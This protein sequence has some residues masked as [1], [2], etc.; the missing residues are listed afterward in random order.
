MVLK[1]AASI[2]RC[3]AAVILVLTVVWPITIPGW[4]SEMESNNYAWSN[5]FR[6]IPFLTFIFGTVV[7]LL[8]QYADQKDK[9]LVKLAG[10]AVVAPW[11]IAIWLASFPD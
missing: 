2:V 5:L 8:R 3:A 4:F 11:I 9:Y 10:L 6:D 1:H 7:F